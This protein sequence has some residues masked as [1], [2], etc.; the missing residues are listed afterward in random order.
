MVK[1]LIKAKGHGGVYFWMQRVAEEYRVK[2]TALIK[3]ADTL[4]WQTVQWENM[5]D[6]VQT[7]VLQQ[8]V[9]K[10]VDLGW[11]ESAKESFGKEDSK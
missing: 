3:E 10:M 1:K 9:K 2:A 8:L 4:H 5:S 7:Q 11:E 6:Q